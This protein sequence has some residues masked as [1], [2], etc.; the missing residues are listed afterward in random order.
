MIESPSVTS[1]RVAVSV[2]TRIPVNSRRALVLWLSAASSCNAWLWVC[3]PA[4]IQPVWR[5]SQWKV[6]MGVAAGRWRLT[7]TCESAATGIATGSLSSVAPSAMVAVRRPPGHVMQAAG[8]DRGALGT[9]IGQGGPADPD[10][11]PSIGICQ[12]DAHARSSQADSRQ[13][14]HRLVVQ[15]GRHV[16]GKQEVL[17]PDR[18][19]AGLPAGGP[20]S[21]RRGAG[22]QQA[23]REREGRVALE[24]AAGSLSMGRF[25]SLNSVVIL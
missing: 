6:S 22:V 25:M 3:S 17:S 12:D 16:A 1:V 7:S 2:S 9:R 19:R 10:R 11:A 20:G 14:P 15:F 13:L 5:P 8:G 21:G 23:R 24:V 4:T 18:L